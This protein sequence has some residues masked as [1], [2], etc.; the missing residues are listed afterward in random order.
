VL[1]DARLYLVTGIAP[2]LEW[3]L[4]EALA[5]GVDVVQL[6]E[7]DA[8][9]DE[10]VRAG[11]VFRRLTREAGA[12]FVLNDRPDLAMRCDADGVHV[13]QDDIPVA[14]VRQ[15]A[16]E[17]LVGLSTHSPEQI[18]AAAGVD[19]IGVG[20]V[21][22]TPTKA[23]R[24]P[25][26][27]ELVR[28]AARSATVPWF[29]IGGIDEANAAEVVAAGAERLAVVRAIRDADDPRAASARLRAALPG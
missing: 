1:E 25:V 29:A 18:H 19:Y 5:G 28:E 15:L 26:G 9:D 22:A 27:L 13:G 21:Y 2:R 11:R 12:L 20:P 4:A 24:E 7:K 17:L 8:D 23:G 3:L 16:P 6:R 14:E 10:I